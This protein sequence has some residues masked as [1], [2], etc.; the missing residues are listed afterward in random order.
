MPSETNGQQMRRYI[1]RMSVSIVVLFLMLI[2]LG[3]YNYVNASH[4]HSTFCNFYD[5]LQHQQDDARAF[6]AMSE[7]E[8]VKKFGPQ[9]GSIPESVIQAQVAS[10][11]VTLDSLGELH[12]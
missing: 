12:C 6:L 5:N 1:V 9:I 3:V 10:R 7:E 2:A 8:R 4:V 11:Q